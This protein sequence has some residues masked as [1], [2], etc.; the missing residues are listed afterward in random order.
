M[1]YAILSCSWQQSELNCTNLWR[2][3]SRGISV[4]ALHALKVKKIKINNC[5]VSFVLLNI[6]MRLVSICTQLSMKS[7]CVIPWPTFHGLWT[8]RVA[9]PVSFLSSSSSPCGAEPPNLMPLRICPVLFLCFIIACSPALLLSRS[10]HFVL[11]SGVDKSQQLP[12]TSGCSHSMFWAQSSKTYA[13]VPL[14]DQLFPLG[15]GEP[16]SMSGS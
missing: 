10:V 14:A 5:H 2:V 7:S 4:F 6:F 9:K 15:Q 1:F 8:S 12:Q 13:C 16:Q 11:R 3:K